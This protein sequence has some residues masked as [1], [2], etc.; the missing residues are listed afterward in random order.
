MSNNNAD[1]NSLSVPIK[2]KKQVMIIEPDIIEKYKL[3]NVRKVENVKDNK[4]ICYSFVKV[5][6]LISVIS[7]TV[8]YIWKK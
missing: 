8:F 3:R 7:G 4:R 5:A 1:L 6:V 2:R